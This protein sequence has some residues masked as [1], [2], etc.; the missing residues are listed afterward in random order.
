MCREYTL[1]ELQ[2]SAAD[3]RV[4]VADD[5]NRAPRVVFDGTVPT[6]WLDQ[7]GDP[8]G[9]IDDAAPIR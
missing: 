5:E 7:R 2:A 3:D 4:A 6:L 8:I 9:P 1:G